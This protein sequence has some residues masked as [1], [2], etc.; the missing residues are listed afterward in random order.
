[1]PD[2]L[3]GKLATGSTNHR[4]SPVLSAHLYSTLTCTLLSRSTFFSFLTRLNHAAQL[5]PSGVYLRVRHVVVVRDLPIRPPTHSLKVW[6]SSRGFCRLRFVACV[7][8]LSLTYRQ[9]W[10]SLVHFVVARVN[11][12]VRFVDGRCF[13]GLHCYCSIN[14]RGCNYPSGLWYRERRLSALLNSFSLLG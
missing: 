11:R 1:M 10:A 5:H 4:R 12:N 14:S 3:R 9:A 8:S 13:E 2:R 7:S 6:V